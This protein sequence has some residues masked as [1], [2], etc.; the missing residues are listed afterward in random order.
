M[1]ALHNHSQFSFIDG[2][3]SIERMVE[4]AVFLGDDSVALTDH[5]EVAGQLALQ[6]A[7]KAA[8]IKALH[9][10][11][12]YLI[13]DWE[14][15]REIGKTPKGYSENSSHITLIAKNQKG[16]KNL[17]SWAT[18]SSMKS[19][20]KPAMDWIH[21]E[22]YAGD[23]IAT[24]GCLMSFL[25]KAIIADDENR[26]HELM[27]KYL[28]LFGDDFRMELHTWQF[29]EPKTEDQLR[30][31]DEMSKVNQVKVV[32]AEQYGVPLLVV[33]D[34]HYPKREDWERHAL[35]WAMNTH[36]NTD[37]TDRGQTAAWMMQDA[38]MVYFME[39][40]GVP[41]A[42]T[43]QAIKNNQAV[44]DECNV[45]IKA[46]TKMPRLYE[47]DRDDLLAFLDMIEEG[48]QRKV[49]D[50]GLPQEPY[51]E[52]ME[53]EARILAKK[54]FPGY[55]NVVANITRT[56]KKDMRMFLGPGRGS[57]GGSLCSYLSDITEMDP[58]KYDL[59]FERFISEDR[60]GWP[61]I[62]VDFPKSRLADIKQYIGSKFGEDHVC[63]IGTVARSQPKGILNDLCRAM[64]VDFKDSKAISKAIGMLKPK[65][66]WDQMMDQKAT[67]L[68]PW[69]KAYP[70]LFERGSQMVNMVRQ[71]GT[72]A[73][74]YL[75]SSDP[76]LGN[77]PMRYVAKDGVLTSSFDMNEVEELGYIK[78]DL[79]GLRHCDTIQ[80]ALDMI[81][82]RHGVV[83]NPYEF[84]DKEF[85]DPA[86]WEEVGNGDCL[87]LFQ[88]DADLM[89]Q[90][91]KRLKPE[92][93]LEVAELLAIN[94]PGVIGAG[95]LTP[96]IER[97]H[98]REEV[99]FDHPIMEEL[100]GETYGILIYQ[101]Q[102][103]KMS[104]RI[105][106]FTP[107]QAEYLRGVV[108]KKKIE[109][110]PALK[111]M[112]VEGCRANPEF[113]AQC[114]G[115]PEV[116]IARL[117]S[118]VE[119]SGE[120]LFNKSHSVA[121]ALIA[122]WEAWLRH[123]YYPEFITATLI[124]DD[125][126]GNMPRYV[127]HAR[128]N[129]L[130][131]LPPDVNVSADKF[132][133]T[134]DGIRYGLTSV[135]MVG[136]NAFADILRARSEAPFESFQDVFK[137]V[138]RSKVNKRVML[139]LIRIGAFDKWNPDRNLVEEEY[140]S[141]AKTKPADQLPPL[142][143][144]DRLEMYRMEKDIVGGYILYDPLRDYE[145][146]IEQACLD[147]PEK[148]DELSKGD[149]ALVGGLVSSIKTIKTKKGDAMS[150]VTV[151]WQQ[152]D[153]EV[154]CFPEAWSANK[155]LLEVDVPV[156]CRISK[157]TDG[158]NIVAV[159]RLDYLDHPKEN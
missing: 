17:W 48:F 113:M 70:E 83:V 80:E 140:Y 19:Y 132:V 97:K 146:I 7:C 51:R 131:V 88:L 127:R 43:L 4:Q 99:E 118:S 123:Y 90:T 130:E 71:S 125:E 155:R 45:E 141:L 102:M 46:E 159:Q 40:H 157:L 91:A 107:S 134:E 92:S 26:T 117:W 74:G 42:V 114:P 75:I 65:T 148:I 11:E 136:D 126:A 101:E 23:M 147:K 116:V 139:N 81:E 124:T 94:R 12:G 34:S 69:V 111:A 86:I 96:Y 15:I 58:L 29:M 110:L 85:Q 61:D 73:S 98:G 150:F 18:V 39:K 104:R 2:E 21:A 60:T 149:L 109:E 50:R 6:K 16:L 72:H 24:D 44:A 56:A 112:F 78:F 22:Q 87:G 3:S 121:Y 9:G 137:R 82:S 63:G 27:G 128:K 33:N 10:M 53:Y 144:T 35:V 36:G 67:E 28:H 135:K 138:T 32:L 119:A 13:D 145:H 95:L 59:L 38:E 8:G 49:V 62:D 89:T 120:Y 30:L 142:D 79:L 156:V 153:F 151:T 57:A 158:C 5:G 77:L 1:V 93:E 68:E 106:G 55:F 108:G 47:T 84:G 52:R 122:S 64:G 14:T 105:A 143:T 20:R 76:L 100:V 31:N 66:T 133:L 129:K 154:T 115:D 103:M 25:A 54:G 41:E 152:Q 37:Q